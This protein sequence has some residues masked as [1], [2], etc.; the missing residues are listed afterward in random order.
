VLGGRSYLSADFGAILA[1]AAESH[2]QRSHRPLPASRL[3][4]EELIDR[5]GSP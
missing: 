1:V 2:M 4:L 5:D 3:T